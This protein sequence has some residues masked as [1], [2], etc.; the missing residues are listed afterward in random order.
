MPLARID[1]EQR[2]LRDR[3]A[4]W[5]G[6]ALMTKALPDG[7]DTTKDWAAITG[8]QLTG[9]SSIAGLDPPSLDHDPLLGADIGGVTIVRLIAEGGMGRVYEGV[10]EKPRRS[11]A[12]KVIRPGVHS[13]SLL[14]RFE[15]EAHVLGSLKHPGIAQIYS[16]GSHT[17][18]GSQV[19]FFVMEYITNAEP[20]VRYAE[21]HRLS[22]HECLELFRQV[23][24]A[25][26]H[27]HHKGVIHRDLKPS[28]ILVDSLGQPKV[29]DFGVARSTNADLGLTTMQTDVGQLIGTIKYMSPEQFDA[30]PDSID[31]RSDVYALGVVLYEL[32]TGRLPY[33]IGRKSVGEAAR[34]V[35]EEDP[36][37]LSSLNHTLHRDVGVIAAKCLEKD[38]ERR[39]SSASE[40]AADIAR[41]LE[42]EAISASP[43]TLT[44]SLMR[45]ARKHKAAA[46]ASAVVILTL[47]LSLAGIT[48]FYIHAEAERKWADKQRLKAQAKEAEAISRQQ[49]TNRVFS[50][51]VNSLHVP[52]PVAAGGTT[53]V[54]GLLT[55]AAR[56]ATDS[57]AGSMPIEDR[58]NQARLLR[59]IGTSLVNT[60]ALEKGRDILETTRV[61]LGTSGEAESNETAA[62][63]NALGLEMLENGSYAAAQ[64][65]F[66]QV[67]SL[68]EAH[69]DADDI[70]VASCLFN[71][72]TADM[73]LGDYGTA[74][75]LF[76]RSL[77]IHESRLRPDDPSTAS[78]LAGLG[79]LHRRQGR[80]GLA[81]SFQTRA[82][83]IVERAFGVQHPATARV[84]NDLGELFRRT[85]RYPEAER[86]HLRARAI[87][88][89]AFGKAHV[90][91]TPSLSKLGELYHVKGDYVAA[92]PLLRESLKNRE[93]AG[94]ECHPETAVVVLRLACLCEDCHR[95]A[96]AESFYLRALSIREQQLGVNH[97]DTGETLDAIT[98]F[99]RRTGRKP[100][101]SFLRM[102]SVLP[103]GSIE[104]AASRSWLFRDH[105]SNPLP[106]TSPIPCSLH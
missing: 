48:R 33:D 81:A 63:L 24:D 54:E 75:S 21:V 65:Y 57:Q 9:L 86:C 85:G 77:H 26:A 1:C 27:G 99:Y 36:A 10:Q 90:Y 39:Y 53:T 47:L 15:Y 6:S 14:K 101:A 83:L 60:G 55:R 11:I 20:L 16:V 82:L 23:C 46:V 2:W 95:Y 59:T 94:L 93:E 30:D 73:L 74:L 66:A 40:L 92:E 18:G 98:G 106:S 91:A 72:A 58:L 102:A 96:E 8:S 49:S 68:L 28:N 69:E 41:Y 4:T 38:P 61:L 84:L 62:C 71:L 104:R 13:S 5:T 50:L 89:A 25:V 64:T 22:P 31:V 97:P 45:L 12:V 34:V 52:D 67:L 100:Q 76:K 88:E 56:L 42:G 17:I 78:V 7:P 44:D 37:P 32:L 80:Y 51:L 3:L 103:P 105:V 87:Q 29:I 19:P 35:K 70:A 79:E 43:P